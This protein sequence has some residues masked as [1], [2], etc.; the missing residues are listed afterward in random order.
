MEIVIALAVVA[1]VVWLITRGR[2]KSPAPR[3]PSPEWV[4]NQTS[5]IAPTTNTTGYTPGSVSADE[6]WI[7][8]GRDV[9]IAGYRIPDGMVYLGKGLAS[10]AG[11]SVEPALIDPS[12][13]TNRSN[14]DRTGG[15]MT[16][17]PSYSSILPE[18]RAAYLDWLAAGR[19]DPTA[20]IGYVFLYF[21]G[22][23]R[24]ALGDAL[25]SEKAGRDVPAI[26]REVEQLL[27]VYAGNGSFQ[28]YATQFLD[29]LKVMSVESTEFE[30]PM[31]RAGYELPVSLRVG[32]GRIIAAGKPLPA[33]WAL[34]WFLMH[35]ETSLRTPAKRCP[36][37]FNELF[38]TRYRREFGDGL[39]LKPNRSKLKIAFRPASASFGG[40]VELNMDLPDI[41]ALTAPLSKLRQIGE[42]CAADLDAFSRWVGRNPAAPKTI[43]AVALLP[44]ELATSHQSQEAEGLWDWIKSVVG[45][46]D[47]V[48]CNADDLLCHCASFG[49]GKL[50]KSEAVLLAQ[51]LEKGGYGIEPDVRFGGAPVTPGGMVVI[52]TLPRDA[53]AIASPQ[54]AAATVLLHLAVA[55]SAADGSI[56]ESEKQQLEGHMARTLALSTTERLRLS[57]HLVWLM[58]SQPSLTGLKKR[59]EPLDLRQRSAMADFIIGVAGADGQI[60]PDEIRTVSKVYPMLGLAADDVYSHI[61]AMAAGAATVVEGNEPITV[62]PAQ[63]STGYAI[64][65][66]PGP[67]QTVQLD[68]TTVKTKL[69]ESAQVAAILD[70][71]FTDEDT[72]NVPQSVQPLASAGKVPAAHGVLL[73]RLAERSEWSRTE[74]E[75]IAK[76]C[77]LMPDGAIDMLNEAAFEHTGAPVI[78]GDDPIQV[79]AATA[80]ELVT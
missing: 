76:E 49:S 77:G 48:M 42:S 13:P 73:S 37:E 75:A 66:R 72:L 70:D 8:P 9:T 50:S 38:H 60:S 4:A 16:Y 67:T 17:W 61:H 21:Y 40:Q 10:V 25:R 57:A 32:I 63:P 23:E 29:V 7:P 41:A 11:Y 26:I 64:P 28:N 31:E 43:A 6:C 22:L 56:S 1:L 44:S 36:E 52:F 27:Q 18:C 74:F 35:P 79:D 12:L 46:G 71:I 59:L 39:V 62:I 2:Q 15:G 58:A 80:K 33:N 51:L 68:M 47:R 5:T 24:R 20:Y 19:R 30:P 65:P 69:A 34:S 54:Y 78:E 53:T 14:S 55:V 45:Q 3:P